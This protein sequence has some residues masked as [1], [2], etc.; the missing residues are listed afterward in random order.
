MQADAAERRNV[1]TDERRVY[2]RMRDA[3]APYLDKAVLATKVDPEEARKLAALGYLSSTSSAA[4]GALPDPKDRIGEIGDMMRAVAL[5]NAGRTDEAVAAFRKIV[6]V[7]PRLA[8]AW[9]ELGSAL[10]RAGRYEE[11]AEVYK[12]AI[13]GAPELAGELGLRCASMLLYLERYAEA[14]SYARLAEK[15]NPGAAHLTL[16]RIALSAKQYGKATTEAQAALDD[17]SSRIEAELVMARAFAQQDRIAEAQQALQKAAADMQRQ[18]SG[19]VQSFEYT[20]GDILARMNR[21]DDAIA[22]FKR[23]TELFP[24][25]RQ[26]YANLY[27]VY[28]LLNR[29]GEA[30]QTLES[31]VRAIPS[32]DTMLFAAKT[33][34]TLGQSAT[35]ADWKRR[36]AARA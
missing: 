7:N 2:A 36:A 30:S 17:A 26:A 8:D 24:R 31:M 5:M 3:L 22:A 4:D 9:T 1:L 10:D 35:A 33:A 15:S 29:E 18:K 16:A 13:A 32:R 12:K 34:Q 23:E 6:A 14:E 28:L 27:L 19:P 25:N 11:A 20:R 21:Y